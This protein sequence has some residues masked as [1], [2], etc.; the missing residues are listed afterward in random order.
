MISIL[1]ENTQKN[2]IAVLDGVR[3]IACLSVV[4]FHISLI[5]ISTHIWQPYPKTDFLTSAIAMQG[6]TGVTL[7]FVLSGFLLFMPYAR[8][9]LFE[10]EQWPSL[11]RFYL[12]R[13]FRIWPAYYVA[14]ALLIVLTQ[15]QYLTL[16]HLPNLGL[17]LIFFMDASAQTY[18]KI[19]GP[20]WTLAVEWQYYLL[21][22]LLAL[23]MRKLVGQGSL[24][25][26]WWRLVACLCALTVWGIVSRYW[27]LY[28]TVEHP[29]DTFLVPRSILNVILFFLYGGNG[30]FLEDFAI[31]MLVS[32][33]F[34]LARQQTAGN[35]LRW[36]DGWLKRYSYWIW[37]AGLLV[38][39]FMTV[40][41]GNQRFHVL[42]F[43]EPLFT[44]YSWLSE[45]GLSLGFGL[46]ILALLFGSTLLKR[47][48]EWAPL[49]W[50][51]LISYG[52]YIWHLPLLIR[53][54]HY[55]QLMQFA[56]PAWCAYLLY[57]LGVALVIVPF[58]YASFKMIERPWI[59]LGD[60]FLKGR[61]KEMDASKL[62]VIKATSN[63][64]DPQLLE[65]AGKHHAVGQRF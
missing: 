25:Q 43:L 8:A 15:P 47:P 3:A 4:A 48:F 32:S 33:C 53:I 52:M 34:V 21:L 38:L 58:S 45:F 19:N 54:S 57:W 37:G 44:V 51:G 24:H 17:F 5:A 12:R 13:M 62:T 31:G 18:Q 40:W 41:N 11:K 50:V 28:F 7:F 9:M 20:F 42:P 49:R 22:P 30:K 39:F 35:T 56:L 46:C 60:K 64:A 1:K 2:T 55:I 63:A 16:A 36:L 23:A 6:G 29:N 65:T 10:Q 14:L 27:G 26:R 61:K 59:R